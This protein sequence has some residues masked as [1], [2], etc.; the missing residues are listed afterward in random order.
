MRDPDFLSIV[1][2]TEL[3]IYESL[4]QRQLAKALN[5]VLAELN[6]LKARVSSKQM[7]D[8]VHAQARFTL[9][10]CLE[11]SKLPAERAAARKLLS[12]FK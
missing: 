3:R 4:A 9:Q 7:W 1:D 11:S 8:S 12:R 10:P 5:G 2:L 6:D